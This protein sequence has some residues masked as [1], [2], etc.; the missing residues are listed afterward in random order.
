MA[1]AEQA[2]D[3]GIISAEELDL[4]H[5]AEAA[6]DDRIQVDAFSLEEYLQTSLQPA[7]DQG[8]QRRKDALAG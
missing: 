8:S 2:K 3:R 4:M 7:A 1:V 5:A 6:R